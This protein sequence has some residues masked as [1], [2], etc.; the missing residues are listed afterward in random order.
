MIAAL[1]LGS[2]NFKAALFAADGQRLS[3]ASLPL[4]Y[5]IHTGKRAELDPE[6]IESCFLSLLNH[7]AAGAERPLNAIE[8]IAITSQAQTFLIAT[9]EG[10]PLSP[11]YGW[12]DSRADEAAAKLQSQLDK[13][14]HRHCGW[15]KVSPG[16][17]LA[18]VLWWKEHHAWDKT[19]RIISLPAYLA[20][21]LGAEHGN[22]ANLAA[23]SGFY[24]L[25][26]GKWWQDALDAS[27]VRE[28]Q[29]GTIV[30]PGCPL[31]M[32]PAK[33]PSGFNRKLQI[34]PVGND[35]TAGAIGC[36]CR[37]GRPILTLGTA[38]VLYRHA[39][40]TPGPY[41]DSGLWGPYPQGGYYELQ[42]LNH[43]CSALDWANQTLLGEVDSPRFAA[44]AAEVKVDD[45]IPFFYPLQ[46]GSDDAWIG[47][48]TVP[49]RAYAAFEGILF[50]LKQLAGE[51]FTT[52]NHALTLLGGGSRLDFWA[53]MASDCFN[54]PV[55]RTEA[56][57]LLGAAR[58]AAP[59][60]IN[61]AQ[62]TNFTSADLAPNINRHL[63]LEQRYQQLFLT[64]S[65]RLHPDS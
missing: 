6:A 23:M 36:D 17:T 10:I 50:A 45:Q 12:S 46:W 58:L 65:A 43:A 35:H 41:S 40:M 14:F 11:F 39:G 61:P 32:R 8:R 29:L 57:G 55:R 44:I 4:P 33:I 59:D 3:E 24:S 62:S 56:D 54:V 13:N 15:P 37:Q 38:G 53:Q 2:T 30:S 51:D 1:D 5:T 60:W 34:I 21:V 48:G 19:F 49:E 27:G 47:R 9:D 28:S 16:L 25:I 20:M 52:S 63:M 22:D 42:C 64:R 26:E 31:A 7:L 18:K